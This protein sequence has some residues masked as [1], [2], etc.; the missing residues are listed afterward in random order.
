MSKIRVWHIPVRYDVFGGLNKFPEISTKGR[1]PRV[2]DLVYYYRKD[3][4]NNTVFAV[5]HVLEL[6]RDIGQEVY[7]LINVEDKQ[8]WV[9]I[10]NLLVLDVN[11]VTK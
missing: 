1:K 3:W 11:N 7:G 2:G 5:S 8:K 10:N 9:P 6:R 4:N